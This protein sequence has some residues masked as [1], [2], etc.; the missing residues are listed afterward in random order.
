M[1]LA[2]EYNPQSAQTEN[3]T[4]AGS[5]VHEIG[6]PCSSCRSNSDGRGEVGVGW[7]LANKK[8]KWAQPATQPDTH[9]E[10]SHG[11]SGG[12]MRATYVLTS[13]PNLDGIRPE[14]DDDGRDRLEL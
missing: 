12:S 7:G 5:T 10:N 4:S 14:V 3:D 13:V 9:G 6:A 8:R 11:G 2:N 1:G